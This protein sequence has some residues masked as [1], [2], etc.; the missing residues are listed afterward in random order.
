MEYLSPVNNWFP[1]CLLAS[2]SLQG[3]QSHPQLEVE[4]LTPANWA[5]ACALAETTL[6]K[7]HEQVYVESGGTPCRTVHGDVRISNILVH[8]TADS[9]VDKVLFVDFDWAGLEG[10]SRCVFTLSCCHVYF[11]CFMSLLNTETRCD[12]AGLEGVC[13]YPCC[14]AAMCTA[15]AMQPH[16]SHVTKRVTSDF[17]SCRHHLPSHS[18]QYHLLAPLLWL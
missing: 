12:W 8:L 7:T 3:A 17:T 13:M 6:K 5:S 11:V 16:G 15:F 4:P 2:T 14:V 1:M 18:V 9:A 10:I